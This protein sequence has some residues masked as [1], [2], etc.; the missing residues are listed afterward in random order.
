MNKPVK[1]VP[2]ADGPEERGGNEPKRGSLLERAGNAFGFDRL[3]PAR[4][5]P[6]LPDAKKRMPPLKSAPPAP[7]P[8]AS[9]PVPAP[10]PTAP[11]PVYESAPAPARPKREEVSGPAVRFPAKNHAVSREQLRAH[12]LIDPDAATSALFE[13]FRIVK[14]QVL[15]TAQADGTAL[16]RRVLVTSPHMG[17]GKTFCS[18]NLALALAAEQDIEVLLVDADFAK[19]SIARRLGLE[20]GAGLMDAL[21]GSTTPVENSVLR[22][23]IANL[24]VLPAGQ[25]TQRDAELL[26]S[27][28]TFEVLGRL[29][30]GAPNRILVFD[31]PPALAA[32][33]AAE[34]A[35]HVGQTLLV[36]RA[37]NTSRVALEDAVD[38]LAGCR[39]IRLL[40]NDATFS[41]SGRSFGRYYGMGE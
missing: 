27:E 33:P 10:A 28:R 19:P 40:L 36:A 4:V 12:A 26:A 32:S 41:P 8:Q 9:A 16:S 11:T 18:I 23:D 25:R 38:L 39:D 17:E 31:S 15:A 6:R 2:P 37:D 35:K 22:T 20:T 5:P 29:T 3:A 7:D 21:A 1:I 24:F 14:R 30:R 34:L 13:E